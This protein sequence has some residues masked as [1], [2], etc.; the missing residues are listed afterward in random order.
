[1][2]GSPSEFAK[3]LEGIHD[4]AVAETIEYVENNMLFTLMGVQGV[5]QLDIDGLIAA[6]FTHA[7]AALTTPD[8]HTH[9]PDQQQGP[10]ARP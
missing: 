1:M 8:L 10:G 4:Q 5:A 3:V 7:T 9:V 6:T 2:G